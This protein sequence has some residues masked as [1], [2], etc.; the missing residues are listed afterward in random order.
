MQ[1]L[2]LQLYPRPFLAETQ[3]IPWLDTRHNARILIL[4]PLETRC[5]WLVLL[6][7]YCSESLILCVTRL[8]MSSNHMQESLDIQWRKDRLFNK[9]CWGNWTD[10]CK[11]MK[12][13][14]YL[15]ADPKVRAKR[16]KELTLKDLNT[17]NSWKKT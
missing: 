14:S 2:C 8:S 12:L 16:I 11:T 6:R 5:T 4:L 10:T 9:W 13:N 1:T 17:Q 7:Y 15:T 3:L